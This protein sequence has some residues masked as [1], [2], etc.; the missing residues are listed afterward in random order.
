M[1]SNEHNPH[2]TEEQEGVIKFHPVLVRQA[3]TLTQSEPLLAQLNAARSRLKAHALLGQDPA[4][5]GGYGFGNISTRLKGQQFLI[6]GS[7]T[8]QLAELSCSDVALVERIDHRTNRLWAHGLSQPSSESMTHGVVYQTLNAAEAVVHVHSPEIWQ[9]A[10]EL[11]L[12]VTAADIPYGTPEMAEAVRHL[13]LQNTPAEGSDGLAQVL[14]FAM[15]G[16]EDGIVAVGQDLI[17]CTDEL[18]RLLNRARD[19]LSAP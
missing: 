13:L 5:Y 10:A 4:R 1:F 2:S 15:L 11:G 12:P 17:R 6:S 19:L 18:L 7:Q 14:V 9:A 3:I 8:G 16:H